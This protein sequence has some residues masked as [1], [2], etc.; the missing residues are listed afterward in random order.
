MK[1]KKTIFEL[2]DLKEI[3]NNVSQTN[4]KIDEKTNIVEGR[5]FNYLRLKGDQRLGKSDYFKGIIHPLWNKNLV[6]QNLDTFYGKGLNMDEFL[7][8]FTLLRTLKAE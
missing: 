7:D 5:R 8:I 3:I 2:Q 4:S 1:K 6:I